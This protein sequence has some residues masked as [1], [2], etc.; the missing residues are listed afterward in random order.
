MTVG[1]DAFLSTSLLGPAL[2]RMLVAHPNLKFT[3]RTGHWEI[4]ANQLLDEEIDIY[5]GFPP[6]RQHPDLKFEPVD[7][8]SPLILGSR[9]H[10]MAKPEETRLADLVDYPIVSPVPPN[11][12]IR[13][14]QEQVEQFK[15]RMTVTGP[16]IL[17]TDSI[18]ICKQMIR[19]DMAL[20][21]AMRADVQDELDSGDIVALNLENWPTTMESCIA[22]KV[23][24][25]Q[26]PAAEMLAKIYRE[27]ADEE[28]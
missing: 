19:N 10:E 27:I 8:S 12:Y 3:V 26:S 18:A 5:I 25:V 28:M 4:F 9:H 22:T 13:W 14:A 21:A 17:E 16:M 6:D 23:R 7:I 20:M 1:V 15:D 2:S 11:W 24:R